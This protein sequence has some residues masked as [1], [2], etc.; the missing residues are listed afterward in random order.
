MT[1]IRPPRTRKPRRPS[2]ED[3]ASR[4]AVLFV[5][6]RTLGLT[7][8]VRASEVIDAQKHALNPEWM[9]ANK[10]LFSRKVVQE[11]NRLDDDMFAFLEARASNC[12]MLADGMWLFSLGLVQEVSEAVSVW[13]ARRRALGRKLTQERP[14]GEDRT[15]YEIAIAEAQA[16]L[17]DQFNAAEYPSPAEVEAKFDVATRWLS[18]NVPAALE[19]ANAKVYQQAMAQARQEWATAGDE[20]RLALRESFGEIVGT[21]VDRLGSDAEG[22]PKTFRANDQTLAKMQEFLAL[23]MQRD[24]T[25][26]DALG[27]L[28][29]QAQQL[30]KGVK[31]DDVKQQESVRERVTAGVGALA[32]KLRALDVR[33]APK[34]RVILEDPA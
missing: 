6:R 1:A 14:E 16:A 24:L 15:H 5:Q 33:V 23:F 10:K 9:G 21:L 7:R 32:T 26:D 17:G 12:S 19:E 25:G 2:P 18:Y 20:M 29:R 27:K 13:T 8:R 30:L 34:R 4:T 28:V 22:N 11:V 3:L 31:V